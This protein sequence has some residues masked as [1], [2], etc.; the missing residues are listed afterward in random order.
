MG[1]P[2]WAAVDKNYLRKTLNASVSRT[3]SRFESLNDT[4]DQ[5]QL[6]GIRHEIGLAEIGLFSSTISARPISCR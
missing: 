4:S 1:S 3:D 2:K 5:E 6:P